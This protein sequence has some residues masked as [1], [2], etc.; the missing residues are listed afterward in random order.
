MRLS[1]HDY[2]YGVEGLRVLRIHDWLVC[3]RRYSTLLWPDLRL[4]MPQTYGHHTR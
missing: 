3:C 4:Q 2:K 1:T